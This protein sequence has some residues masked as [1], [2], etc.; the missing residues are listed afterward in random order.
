MKLWA[1][2]AETRE[3]CISLPKVYA[4]TY[5]QDL[6]PG[7]IARCEGCGGYTD[8]KTW[9]HRCAACKADVEPGTLTGLFVPH[10]CQSCERTLTEENYASGNVCSMCRKARNQCCC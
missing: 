4:A 10:N 7:S 3:R 1:N 5:A 8:G 9:W 2:E 6:Y